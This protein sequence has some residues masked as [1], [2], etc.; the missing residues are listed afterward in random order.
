MRTEIALQATLL[1]APDFSKYNGENTFTFQ[2]K[3]YQKRS[4]ALG[5]GASGEV[6]CFEADDHTKVAVKSELIFYGEYTAGAH[7]Q[8]EAA[9]YQ[10]IYGHGVFSGD[11]DNILV[12]HYILMPYF[13]GKTLYSLS[14]HSIHDVLFSWI[15]TAS[16]VKQLHEEHRVVHGDLKSDNVIFGKHTDREQAFVIDF[17]LASEIGALRNHHVVDTD[18]NR[19]IYTQYAPEIFTKRLKK[20][21]Q[22]AQPHQD[23]YSLGILLSQGYSLF[24][25]QHGCTEAPINTFHTMHEVQINLT[26][27]DPLQRWSIAKGIFILMTTFFSYIPRETWITSIDE[28]ALSELSHNNLTNAVWRSIAS[29]A[30]YVRH[31]ELEAEQKALEK[32]GKKSD[33]KEQKI[34]GLRQLQSDIKIKNPEMLGIMIANAQVKFPELTAGVF[35]RRTKILLNKLT[36]AVSVCH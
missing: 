18:K 36:A 1:S 23:I 29:I 24:F 21:V 14:Y 27:D 20:Q 19:R 13:E 28:G 15:K 31:N 33:C 10:K 5:S 11:A 3:I 35:S 22:I 6:F 17:G 25:E 26:K 7:F 16:A 2:G 30:I 9:W 34:N 8:K 12:P 4:D 32:R